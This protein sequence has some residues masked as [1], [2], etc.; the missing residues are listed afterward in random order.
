MRSGDGSINT[1]VERD[2]R[3]ADND[4]RARLA[5]PHRVLDRR[6]DP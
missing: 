5:V 2:R 4:A 6:I 1:A 3:A